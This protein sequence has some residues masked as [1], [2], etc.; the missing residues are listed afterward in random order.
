MSGQKLQDQDHMILKH[1]FNQE[2]LRLL[3]DITSKKNKKFQDLKII[4]QIIT[5]Y[6]QNK[7]AQCKYLFNE[8]LEVNKE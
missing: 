5:Q 7:V 1:Y 6:K 4:I 3:L 2:L 8:D